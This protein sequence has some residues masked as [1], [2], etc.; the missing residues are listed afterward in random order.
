M[1]IVVGPPIPANQISPLELL[2]ALGQM[3]KRTYMAVTVF[4]FYEFFLTLDQEI[5]HI[6]VFPLLRGFCVT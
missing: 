4:L 2:I 6:W 5:E 3:T 1:A